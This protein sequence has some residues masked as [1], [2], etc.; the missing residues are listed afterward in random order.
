MQVGPK[1]QRIGAERDGI[2]MNNVAMY[3]MARN[4]WLYLS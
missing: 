2:A 3:A 1:A 4:M